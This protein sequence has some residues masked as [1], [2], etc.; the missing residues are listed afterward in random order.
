ME[1]KVI[2]A[3]KNRIIPLDEKNNSNL[4]ESIVSI[5]K[6]MNEVSEKFKSSFEK[7]EIGGDECLHKK[8]EGCKT[9]ICSGV[10]MISCSCSS[11]SPKMNIKTNIYIADSKNKGQRHNKSYLI[12]W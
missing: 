5:T 12:D 8:C 2:I 3:S 6:L 4:Y 7:D 10:H 9:N 1:N 11:C